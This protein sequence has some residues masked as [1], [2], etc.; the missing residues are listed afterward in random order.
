MAL[1]RY[2][3]AATLLLGQGI[4][5]KIVGDL[6]GHAT[7]SLTLDTYSHLLPAMHQQA[8]A[9]MDALLSA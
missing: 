8:A 3:T 6:L 2:W 5:P 9:A 7:V 1:L 4:H